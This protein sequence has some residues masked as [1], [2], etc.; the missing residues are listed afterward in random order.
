VKGAGQSNGTPL[1]SP[2]ARKKNTSPTPRGGAS[3]F[4][5]GA[6]AYESKVHDGV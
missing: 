2:S 6:E 4:R 5:P 1:G 3:L